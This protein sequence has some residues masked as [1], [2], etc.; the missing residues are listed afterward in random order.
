LQ[1]HTNYS[2]II[3]LTFK[4]YSP[5]KKTAKDKEGVSQNVISPSLYSD[6]YLRTNSTI[7]FSEIQFLF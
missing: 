3:L 7:Q 4:I 2:G 1:F 5:I 6:S